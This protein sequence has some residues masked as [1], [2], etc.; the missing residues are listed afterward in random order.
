MTSKSSKP[1]DHT[2]IVG[3]PS[4]MRMMRDGDVT[5]RARNRT[6]I[7]RSD[8]WLQRIHARTRHTRPVRGAVR[9]QASIASNK[10]ACDAALISCDLNFNSLRDYP[11][12]VHRSIGTEGA[13]S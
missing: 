4:W 9:E 7:I 12:E 2:V 6:T 11:L 5:N 13:S 10:L 8:A 3:D 1:R